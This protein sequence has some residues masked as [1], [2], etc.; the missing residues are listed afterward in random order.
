MPVRFEGERQDG[1]ECPSSNCLLAVAS[2]QQPVG[3][4]Q[5]DAGA[6]GS[7]REGTVPIEVS[8]HEAA[9][10]MKSIWLAYGGWWSMSAV[11]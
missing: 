7:E 9:S 3:P 4:Q 8:Q 6:K 10:P 2:Q 11:D 1:Q 5:F